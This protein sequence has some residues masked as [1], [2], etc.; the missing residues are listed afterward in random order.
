MKNCREV[1]P[2]MAPYVDGD[3]PTA[4]RADID[5]HLERCPACR[6]DI[7]A[8]RAVKA[9]I[10]AR[11]GELRGCATSALRER[12]AEASSALRRTPQPEE[13]D[14]VASGFSRKARVPSVPSRKLLRR[15]PLAAAATL[16]IAFAGVF[17]FGLNN[18]VQALAFQMTLD[19]MACTRFHGSPSPADAKGAGQQW[20][21]RFGWPLT[22]PPSSDPPGVELRVVRRCGVT[23][24]RVAHLIY[25]WR[26][27][28]LS[29]YVL[30]SK[31]LE[32]ATEVQ[33]FGH[34]NVMWTQNGRTYVVLASASRRSDLAGVVQYMRSTVY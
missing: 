16:V 23:D 34:D 13:R 19:H 31:A 6:D 15:I 26:G 9:A 4:D 33:R 32:Q 14:V 12:C 10:H 2:L 21:A 3:V 22:V 29:L 17:A 30:P 20:N 25:Q 1:E 28:P 18:K 11:R 24:G 7:D 27:E 5:A 8:Q